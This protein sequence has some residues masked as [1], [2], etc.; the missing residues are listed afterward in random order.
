MNPRGDP[1]KSGQ[2]IQVQANQW[3]IREIEALAGAGNIQDNK[4]FMEYSS[5]SPGRQESAQNLLQRALAYQKRLAAKP[6]FVAFKPR[7]SQDF[8]KKVIP[9]EVL[10]ELEAAH[11]AREAAK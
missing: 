9:R 11:E 6:T 7:E 1:I 5:L 4:Y 2:L 10:A 8:K 3:N